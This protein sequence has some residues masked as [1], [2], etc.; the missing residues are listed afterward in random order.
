MEDSLCI[1]HKGLR[2]PKFSIVYMQIFGIS[3][4][5]TNKFNHNIIN[6]ETEEETSNRLHRQDIDKQIFDIKVESEPPVVRYNL[7]GF[8]I[9]LDLSHS[10]YHSNII[11]KGRMN[12]DMSIFFN[13]T[14]V[15]AF[16]LMVDN[17]IDNPLS[18]VASGGDISTDQLI[19]L[20]ALTL[21]GEHW[22]K[23]EDKTASN[24]NLKSC[25][26]KVNNLHISADGAYLDLPY[27]L[28]DEILHS[29]ESGFEKNIKCKNVLEY[30]ATLYRKIVLEGQK[31][32]DFKHQDF[33]FVD[34]W[35]DV[36][37]YNSTLQK[38]EKEED[39]IKYIYEDCKKEM[40]GLMS[41]YPKEWPYR[42][43]E[44]FDEVCGNNIAIDTDDLILLNSSIC[45]VFGTYGRRTQG[46]PTD[47]KD[48]LDIRNSYF[49]SWPEYM[50]ILEM[51][52]AKKYTIAAAKD[53]L[54]RTTN[55]D[56]KVFSI[57]KS[58][59]KNAE[60]E[61][62]ITQ[63]LL[64]LDAVNY[65]KFISHK[66]MFDRIIKRLDII[67]DENKLKDIMHKVEN[68]LSTLSN[69]RSLKQAE[70]FNIVLGGISVASLF[71]VILAEVDMPFFAKLGYSWS[72]TVGMLIVG[73]CMVLVFI[74]MISITIVAIQ[75]RELGIS[76]LFHNAW[77]K[78]FFKNRS[79]DL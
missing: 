58:I 65:S 20:V 77:S 1:N 67:N 61:L 60:I 10:D 3:Q 5:N 44:A 51:V 34:I 27:S 52:L 7:K 68:S 8:D 25:N 53:F 46:S 56:Q 24:I 19:S 28:D 63:L 12:V 15:L 31:A 50:L 33:V 42:D 38:M 69:M 13:K 37:N 62:I 41:L 40:V 66:I 26:I 35:E 21:G 74:G 43:V 70:R 9:E 73:V 23:D 14:A 64:K 45:I 36:D 16:S 75:N 29:L 55:F 17:D 76:K 54:L 4:L 18:C 11:I 49:V 57:R 30:V 71:Q 6:E 79:I 47:W 32:Y 39:I 48:H 78:I 72:G 2:Y 59:E 22:S